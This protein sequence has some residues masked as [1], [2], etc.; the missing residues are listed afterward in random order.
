MELPLRDSTQCEVHS[1]I[2]FLATAGWTKVAIHKE[3]KRAYGTDV[4]TITMVG[5]W[6]KYQRGEDRCEQHGANQSTFQ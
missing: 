5:C 1:V 3:L 4:M 6:V 2:R